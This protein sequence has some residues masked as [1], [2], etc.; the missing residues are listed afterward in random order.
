LRVAA[1]KKLFIVRSTLP[2]KGGKGPG[3]YVLLFFF[4]TFKPRVEWY[5][6]SM[7]L[8]YEPASKTLDGTCLLPQPFSYFKSLGGK[9]QLHNNLSFM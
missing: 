8:K 1:A 9:G 5:T 3:W 4:I 7:S 2:C 6:K